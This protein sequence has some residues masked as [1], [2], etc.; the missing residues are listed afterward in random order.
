MHFRVRKNVVQLVR[1]EYRPEIKGG[2]AVVVGSVKLADPVLTEDLRAALTS[3]EV[4]E[5]QEWLATKHRVDTLEQELAAL[6]LVDAL[7]RAE[8]WF[9]RAG[10][11]AAARNA[12][13]QIV[14][15]WQSLRRT[16]SKKGLLG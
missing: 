16:L 7:Q 5:F 11:S 12:A 15:A 9:A 4:A 3:D 14:P 10:D 6:T 13:G 1:M 2:R 8:A